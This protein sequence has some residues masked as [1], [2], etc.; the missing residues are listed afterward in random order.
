MTFNSGTTKF[1]VSVPPS[2]GD[3]NVRTVLSNSVIG[4]IDMYNN[5]VSKRFMK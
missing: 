2:H 1:D 3:S 5:D 4:S